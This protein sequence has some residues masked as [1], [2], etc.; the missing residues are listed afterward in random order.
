MNMKRNMTILQINALFRKNNFQLIFTNNKT[1]VWERPDLNYIIKIFKKDEPYV[2]FYNLCRTHVSG[3]L[4]Q[5]RGKLMRFRDTAYY[6]IRIEKLQKLTAS[7]Y[8]ANKLFHCWMYYNYHFNTNIS[9]DSFNV[10]SYDHNITEPTMCKKSAM[11]FQIKEPDFCRVLELIIDNLP[12][13]GHLDFWNM[14]FMK[15]GDT[16]VIIDPYV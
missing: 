6:A 7:E 16:W 9:N 10:L 14:N 11:E 3:H 5:F 2:K 12:N 15:R 8:N 4:P 1:Y 13:D